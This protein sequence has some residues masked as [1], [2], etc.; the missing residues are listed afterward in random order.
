MRPSEGPRR[1]SVDEAVLQIS[2]AIGVAAGCGAETDLIAARKLGG[3]QGGVC[4]PYQ[5]VA[6]GTLVW[7]GCGS[8]A[9]GDHSRDARK[10]PGGNTLAQFFRDV[11]GVLRIGLSEQNAEFLASITAHH[12]NLP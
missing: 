4:S 3:V 7:K 12:I 2:I 8:G 1:D 10:L 5:F 11:H 9:D 6:A